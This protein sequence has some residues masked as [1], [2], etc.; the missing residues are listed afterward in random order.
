MSGSP[1]DRVDLL[2]LFSSL[3]AMSPDAR[4]AA[5]DDLA[6]RDA[7]SASELESLLR[8]ADA[9]G[10]VSSET[11]DD[12]GRYRPGTRIDAY[13]IDRFIGAGGMGEV[14]EATQLDPVRRRVAIKVMSAGVMSRTAEIRFSIERQTMA[15]LQHP[16]IAKLLDGGV[17]PDRRPY[18]VVEFIDG[19][20]LGRACDEAGLALRDRLEIMA[21]VCDAA[22]HA[23]LQGIV[24]RDLTPWNILVEHG[25]LGLP[26]P[27]IIDFGVA[28]TLVRIPGC[29][30]LTTHDGREPGTPAYMSPEQI[31]GESIDPR[32]DVF[33]L[34][35]ILYE[36]IAG[37]AP[38][39]PEVWQVE[40]SA[41]RRRVWR[42]HR[43][44]LLQQAMRDRGEPPSARRRIGAELEAIVRRA[45]APDPADR[46]ESAAAMG[47][48]L[49]AAIASEPVAALQGRRWHRTR[50]F[51][52]RHRGRLAVGAAISLVLLSACLVAAD[53]WLE[54]RRLDDVVNGRLEVMETVYELLLP[55]MTREETAEERAAIARVAEV[56]EAR[57]AADPVVFETMEPDL[58]LRLGRAHRETGRPELAEAAFRRAI[59]RLGGI[60]ALHG[61]SGVQSLQRLIG[62]ITDQARFD[63]AL[64]LSRRLVALAESTFGTED[65]RAYDARDHLAMI[66]EESGRISEAQAIYERHWNELQERERTGRSLDD[67]PTYRTTRW[68]YAWVLVQRGERERPEAIMR[69]EIEENIRQRPIEPGTLNCLRIFADDLETWGE[70]E[71]ALELQ[72]E[73]L[74]G[75]IA[76]YGEFG[77]RTCDS[78]RKRVAN[79]EAKLGL[80]PGEPLPGR[81]AAE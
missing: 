24:H 79:L 80:A 15:M 62:A 55:R 66:L 60:E 48:D 44:P 29:E 23:H 28:K 16:A 77:H 11:R 10:P 4:R 70:L 35:V 3:L 32:S 18:L 39:P 9:D 27:R 26:R 33:S 64:P 17:T 47:R 36:V 30:G 52:R 49:R 56:M 13:R 38:L 46:Y 59:A 45:M 58:S 21:E 8:Y 61:E 72:R 19:V 22:H 41:A 68:M 1:S 6:S 20:P 12:D 7:A 73:V 78:S 65:G 69:R 67:W 43:V 57:L 53:Q 54:R 50:A 37:R 51:A 71:E 34:G 75:R 76:L 5:L 81:P 40:T 42:T 31:D 14:Y 74:A 2:S 25:E 63:D